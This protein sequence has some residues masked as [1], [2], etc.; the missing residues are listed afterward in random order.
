MIVQTFFQAIR[1]ASS[2]ITHKT[3]VRTFIYTLK[4]K[5]VTESKVPSPSF[6]WA[7]KA[8]ASAYVPDFNYLSTTPTTRAIK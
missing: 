5:H 8:S 4:A 7:T 6:I 3:K 2:A 1:R